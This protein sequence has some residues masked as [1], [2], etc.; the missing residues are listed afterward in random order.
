M[1][2]WVRSFVTSAEVIVIRPTRG[3]L[4]SRRTSSESKRLSCSSTRRARG[5]SRGIVP[6][7]GSE[8][9]GDDDALEALDL[10]LDLDV[11]VALD[12]DAALS[13][14]TNLAGVVL[15]ALQGLEFALE[16]HDVV[17]Q[18]ADRVVAA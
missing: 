14:G 10:V 8:L 9:A 5:Y 2:A 6:A 7:S 1:F 13:A 16:D 18:D 15:E 11:V 12:A 4:T 3:S 17:A